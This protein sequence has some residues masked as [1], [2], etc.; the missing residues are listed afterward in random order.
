[1]ILT[2]QH[3]A[4][5]IQYLKADKTEAAH[6]KEVLPVYSE[7]SSIAHGIATQAEKDAQAQQEAQVAQGGGFDPSALPNP[8]SGQGMAAPEPAMTMA[9]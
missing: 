2:L 9:Q 5:H 8:A 6:L 1:M 7:V 4:G 3:T